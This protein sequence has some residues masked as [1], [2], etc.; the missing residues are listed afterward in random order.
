MKNQKLENLVN[1]VNGLNWED[2][3]TLVEPAEKVNEIM[4]AN[5][6]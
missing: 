3:D 4:K 6:V 5:Q 1:L 2:F